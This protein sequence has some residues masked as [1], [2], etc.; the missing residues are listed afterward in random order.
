MRFHWQMVNLMLQIYNKKTELK[1][2][3]YKQKVFTELWNV[4]TYDEYPFM[5]S[6]FLGVFECTLR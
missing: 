5:N 1:R 4:K 2:A 3:V 6:H